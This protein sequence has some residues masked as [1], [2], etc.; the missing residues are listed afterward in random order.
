MGDLALDYA[1][2]EEH[3][4]WWDQEAG[5]ARERMD[6]DEATIAAAHQAFG[7]IGSS[8]V[9]ASYAAAL[10]AR[11]AL[12]ASSG[13]LCRQCGRPHPP[14]SAD[15]RRR[16]GRRRW[17]T[18]HLTQGRWPAAGICVSMSPGCTARV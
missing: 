18:E 8:T 11:R 7:K 4:G 9:G 1:A 16:R 12:G 15:L 17:H 5:A 3:A 6:V 2:W 10:E 13:R 14:R